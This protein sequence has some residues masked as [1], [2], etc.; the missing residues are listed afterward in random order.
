M[1]ARTRPAY[2]MSVCTFPTS[3]SSMSSTAAIST[4]TSKWSRSTTGARTRRP[5]PSAGSVATRAVATAVAD[6]WAASPRSSFYEAACQVI[7]TVERT[8]S[9]LS[10]SWHTSSERAQPPQ[11]AR[12]VRANACRRAGA[13]RITPSLIVQRG[14]SSFYSRSQVA[15]TVAG[16]LDDAM[17]D[18]ALSVIRL[19]RAARTPHALASPA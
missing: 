14:G 10:S 9:L 8:G 17:G 16:A 3:A 7:H 13:P 5:A 2:S 4:G 15:I 6:G 1:G 19:S 18:A 12:G 11:P